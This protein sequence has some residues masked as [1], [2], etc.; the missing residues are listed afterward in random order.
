MNA[1]LNFSL[2]SVSSST[3]VGR[4]VSDILSDRA[5]QSQLGYGSGN[6][7]VIHDDGTVAPNS[8]VIQAGDSLTIETASSSKA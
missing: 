8:Y 2:N 5:L 1:T 4:S 6:F 3:L 7:R